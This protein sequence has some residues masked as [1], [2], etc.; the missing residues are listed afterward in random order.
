M[1]VVTRCKQFEEWKKKESLWTDLQRYFL[2][3]I[4]RGRGALDLTNTNSPA[5]E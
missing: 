2:D 1:G 4:G 5:S 3:Q